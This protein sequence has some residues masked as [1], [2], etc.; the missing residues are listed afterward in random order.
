[1]PLLVCSS[2]PICRGSSQARNSHPSED[3]KNPMRIKPGVDLRGIQPEMTIA[4]SVA[5]EVYYGMGG[6]AWI[7][8]FTLTSALDGTHSVGSLHYV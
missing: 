8:D 3:S 5:K 1:M 2:H 4:M 6:T 7:K